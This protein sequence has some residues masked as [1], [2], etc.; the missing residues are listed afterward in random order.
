MSMRAVGRVARQLAPELM[1]YGK[2]GARWLTTPAGQRA[3]KEIAKTVGNPFKKPPKNRYIP[4]KFSVVTSKKRYNPYRGMSTASYSGKFKRARRKTSKQTNK[5]TKFQSLGYV[6]T[7][8]VFGKV[9]DPD[10]VYVGHSTYEARRLAQAIGCAMVRKLLKKGGF[11]PDS[12][13]QEIPFYEYNN[14]DGFKITWV[15][16]DPSGTMT[17]TSYITPDN[18]TLESIVANS[19]LAAVILNRLENVDGFNR[20]SFERITLYSSD[21][22]ELATNWRLA[23]ELNLQQEVIVVMS[24]SE[25][26]IQNRTKSDSGSS[27]VEQVDNVPLKGYM[28]EFVG[29][30]PQTKQLE[31]FANTVNFRDG[32]LLARAGSFASPDYKKEPPV[33]KTYNNCKK[34]AYVG[35]NPGTMKNTKISSYWR[36]YFNNIIMGRLTFRSSGVADATSVVTFSPGKCQMFALE[37]R[38][39]SGATNPI[40]V[41]YEVDRKIGV[42]LITTKKP[43]MSMGYTAQQYDDV[44]A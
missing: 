25:L 16:R 10:C 14:S 9:S 19:G 32:V 2:Q 41:Q 37:E 21:R 22:N 31:R 5:L 15:I 44:P 1:K 34:S 38:I 40:T 42:Y 27:D 33:P 29:G 36:G 6:N 43:V 24:T 4:R 3:V 23:A 8:E 13:N 18:A 17:P 12:P 26:V 39:N 28:Y 30:V 7:R 35:L 20:G 11:D